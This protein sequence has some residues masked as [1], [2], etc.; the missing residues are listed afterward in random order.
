MMEP[1]SGSVN[2]TWMGE[3]KTGR[4]KMVSGKI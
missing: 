1:G 3:K 2:A 4:H